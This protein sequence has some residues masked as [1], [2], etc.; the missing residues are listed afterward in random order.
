MY[1]YLMPEITRSA[2][3]R[4]TVMPEAKSSYQSYNF[5]YTRIWLVS[6]A[7][8]VALRFVGTTQNQRGYVLM[9]YMR[10]SW[11]TLIGV[12]IFEG[13][14]LVHYL[15]KHQSELLKRGRYGFGLAGV[16]AWR[17]LGKTEAIKNATT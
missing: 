3:L 10:I 7:I 1:T 9:A 12:N 14:R 6:S 13:Q 16:D 15:T 17:L 11:L 4:G 8:L 2:E 5:L